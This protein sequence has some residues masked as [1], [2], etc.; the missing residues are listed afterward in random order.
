MKI[1]IWLINLLL[2][3]TLVACS[4][5]GGA[6]QKPPLDFDGAYLNQQIQ[7]LAVPQWNTFKTTD[8]AAVKLL[9]M[10][11]NKITFP[12][13]YNLRLFILENKEWIEVK[14]QPIDYPP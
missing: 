8:D 13:N 11:S 10:T 6:A 1:K 9:Y 14:D 5:F 12:P 4:E 7:L 2:G 3:L